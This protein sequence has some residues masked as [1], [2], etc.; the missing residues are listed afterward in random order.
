MKANSIEELSSELSHA[1]Q[2]YAIEHNRQEAILVI[3]E[4]TYEDFLE[5]LQN[6]SINIVHTGERNE[7]VPQ[8]TV[9]QFG[10]FKMIIEYSD[11]PYLHFE[12]KPPK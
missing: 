2:M 12:L 8:V 1:F 9:F 11:L 3:K 4:K 7:E 10:H 5:H 6:T